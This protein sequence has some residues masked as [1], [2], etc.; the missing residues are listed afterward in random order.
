MAISLE[1]F[2][3]A[4]DATVIQPPFWFELVRIGAPDT[5]ASLHGYDGDA[6]EL[7]CGDGDMVDGSVIGDLDG[8]A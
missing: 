2:R 8:G 7:A 1:F 4:W 6:D 5:R 3:L